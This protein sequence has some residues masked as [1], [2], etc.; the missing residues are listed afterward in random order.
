MDQCEL[1]IYLQGGVEDSTPISSSAIPPSSPSNGTPT[2]APSS[3][4][5]RP[6]AGFPACGCTRETLGCST[7]PSTP[8]PWIA[9][10]RDSLARILARQE[11]G[12]ELPES[13]AAS[14]PKS[15]EQLMLLDPPGSCSKTPPLSAPEAGIL[16]SPI[17]WREDIPGA[18]ASCPRLMSAP[19]ISGIDGGVWPTP[20]AKE[21]GRTPAQFV[22]M[23]QSIGRQSVSSLSVADQMWPTPK[24][25]PGSNRRTKPT[26]AQAA[27]KA[28][29]GLSVAVRLWPTPTKSDG[30]GGPGNSGREGGENLR[31]AVTHYPIPNAT[32]YKDPSTR[33]PGKERPPSHDDL[34][35]RIG[36]QLNPMWVAWLMGWPIGATKL[37]PLETGKFPFAR[38]RLG[39]SSEDHK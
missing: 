23:R 28:G 31:T 10:M 17:W 1:D 33:S 20:V 34:P 32:E 2:P 16:S 14:I 27:G 30:M 37:G 26:P 19:R 24:S 6:M 11:K 15:C 21:T 5:V 18:T 38:Q 25:N 35:T 36:G 22:A 7:H 13:E 8:E 29:M 3:D 39:K 9:S 12:P 4:P